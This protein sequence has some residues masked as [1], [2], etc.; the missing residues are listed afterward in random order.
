MGH[1]TQKSSSDTQDLTLRGGLVELDLSLIQLMQNSWKGEV[2]D[3]FCAGRVLCWT[4]S[5]LGLFC[6]LVLFGYCW[7][8]SVLVM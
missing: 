7:T 8:C 2:L 6:T 1:V 5:V 3:V 4:C